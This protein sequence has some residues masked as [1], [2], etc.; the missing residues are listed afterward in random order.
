[1]HRFD[2]TTVRL[3]S[4]R[5]TRVAE[6]M[7]GMH[8]AELRFHSIT[9]AAPRRL[10]RAAGRDLAGLRFARRPRPQ[11][12]DPRLGLFGEQ[13]GLRGQ[14]GVLLRVEVHPRGFGAGARRGA[15]FRG[16]PVRSAA[17]FRRGLRRGIHRRL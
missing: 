8:A 4:D 9:P 5:V 1:M 17:W 7:T 12:V 16:S 3:P 11:R 2:V 10:W 6:D 15:S 14:I 13:A